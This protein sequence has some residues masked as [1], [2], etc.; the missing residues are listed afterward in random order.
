LHFELLI[1]LLLIIANGLL[2]MTEMAVVSSRRALLRQLAE[3]GDEGAKAALEL[4]NN[5]NQLLSTIQTGMTLV[6]TLAGAFGG[7]TIAEELAVYFGNISALAPYSSGLSL[8]AIVL[9]ITIFSLVLGELVPKRIA[10]SN[11]E[12]IASLTAPTLRALSRIVSPLILLLGGSTDLVLRALGVKSY[13][14]PAVTEEE[15]RIMIDQGRPRG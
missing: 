3:D 1:I 11:P 12:R 13:V 5:P 10:L 4:A 6:A 2:S 8:F 15:I 14:E 7:A 9:L